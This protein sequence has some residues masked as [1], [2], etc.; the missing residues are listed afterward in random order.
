MEIKGE[1]VKLAVFTVTFTELELQR[2]LGADPD[3]DEQK[4]SGTDWEFGR[5]I[6]GELRG[7]L[8]KLYRERKW[9]ADQEKRDADAKARQAAAKKRQAAKASAPAIAARAKKPADGVTTTYVP[10]A[11]KSTGGTYTCPGCGRVIGSMGKG[12]HI[13]TCKQYKAN[14]IA[15]TGG[16]GHAPAPVRVPAIEDLDESTLD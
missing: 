10:K 6:E 13:A 16:N 7:R 5:K 4:R 9:K 14:A 12:R 8:C 11:K 3:G 2:W 1:E 15:A